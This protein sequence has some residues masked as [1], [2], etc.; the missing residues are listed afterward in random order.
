MQGRGRDAKYLPRG[1]AAM[2]SIAAT[3]NAAPVCA[4]PISK[5]ERE[6]SPELSRVDVIDAQAAALTSPLVGTEAIVL[7]I[8]E[9]IWY[10]SPCEFGRRSSR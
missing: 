10:G 5:K 8:C 1:V 2:S 9:A 7:R 3:P 6:S 4:D